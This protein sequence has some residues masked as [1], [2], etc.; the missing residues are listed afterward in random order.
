MRMTSTALLLLA[1]CSRPPPPTDP[2]AAKIGDD[3]R[4]RIAIAPRTPGRFC[5]LLD[6]GQTYDLSLTSPLPF[7][8]SLFGPGQTWLVSGMSRTA[9]DGPAARLRWTAHEPGEYM[10]YIGNRGGATGEVGLLVERLSPE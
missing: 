1:A 8:Y 4:G 3:W 10:L 6:R 2:A 7:D 9:E 5:I